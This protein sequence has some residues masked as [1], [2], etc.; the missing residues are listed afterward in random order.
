MEIFHPYV[1]EYVFSS[2]LLLFS[3]QDSVDMNGRSFVTVPKVPGTAYFFQSGFSLLFRLSNFYCLS[4]SSLV[5]S[6]VPSILLLSPSVKFLLSVTEFFTSEICVW[7]CISSVS[8]LRFFPHLFRVC[9]YIC[10]SIFMMDAL[11]SVLSWCL[12]I[13]F[14]HSN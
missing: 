6:F 9:F 10:R 2:A 13:I 1:F 11:T 14:S 5:L 3:F 7:F 8:F 4:S 12:L